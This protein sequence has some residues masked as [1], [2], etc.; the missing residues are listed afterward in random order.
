MTPLNF[1]IAKIAYWKADLI[2][3]ALTEFTPFIVLHQCSYNNVCHQLFSTII[4]AAL[5]VESSRCICYFEAETRPKSAVS[6]NRAL[7][8]LN[9]Y[10]FKLSRIHISITLMYTKC[11]PEINESIC[12]FAFIGLLCDIKLM[13]HHFR[14]S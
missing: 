8:V 13:V 1:F 10:T 4:L 7:K 11:Y 3:L 6:I 12:A 5:L 9:W 14:W 2:I